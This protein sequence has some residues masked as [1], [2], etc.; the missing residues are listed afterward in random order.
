[1]A[2]PHPRN[3]RQC[4]RSLTPAQSDLSSSLMADGNP[5]NLLYYGDNPA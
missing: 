3:N 1:V 4:G 5:T 2:Q